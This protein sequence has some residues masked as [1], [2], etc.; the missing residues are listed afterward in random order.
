MYSKYKNKISKKTNL[1]FNNNIYKNKI[2]NNYKENKTQ[3]KNY[4]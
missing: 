4:K 1:Y 3:K 2:K